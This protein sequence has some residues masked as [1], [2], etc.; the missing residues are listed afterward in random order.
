MVQPFHIP[1][2][3]PAQQKEA[4]ENKIWMYLSK[5][6]SRPGHMKFEYLLEMMIH[7][8][9]FFFYHLK[10]MQVTRDCRFKSTG[11]LLWQQPVLHQHLA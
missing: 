1:T 11:D 4:C 10:T 7:Y 5:L 8:S 3:A 9:Q 6:L 2:V